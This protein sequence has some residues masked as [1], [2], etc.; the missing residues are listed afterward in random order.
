[1]SVHAGDAGDVAAGL[2]EGGNEPRLDGIA[3]YGEH[4]GDC[5]GRLLGRER[6]AQSAGHR[7]YRHL[8]THQVGHETGHLVV[9]AVCPAILDRDVAA[10]DKASL[11]QSI[12][13]RCR[14]IGALCEIIEK[15]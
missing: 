13:E 2:V 14:K 15:P 10:F 8:A 3:T 6:S 7:D 11:V 4:D 9:L 12:T 1:M 5:S